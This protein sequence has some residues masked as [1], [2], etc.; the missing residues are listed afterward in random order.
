MSP[1]GRKSWVY[2][3]TGVC[4]RRCAVVQVR[5]LHSW[6]GPAP[7]V[8]S[9]GSAAK[10]RAVGPLSGIDKQVGPKW[11]LERQGRE[12]LQLSRELP[13]DTSVMGAFDPG[14]KYQ[15]RATISVVAEPRWDEARL[16]VVRKLNNIVAAELAAL[17]QRYPA[18]KRGGMVARH[19]YWQRKQALLSERRTEPTASSGAYSI[20]VFDNVTERVVTTTNALRD[21]EAVV[22]EIKQIKQAIIASFSR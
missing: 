5:L 14:K 15:L 13:L 8:A 6:P 21:E 4:V 7:S 16:E 17:E 12:R 22:A 18:D 20:I 2:S 19:K 10:V 9:S 3:A 1:H 11:K